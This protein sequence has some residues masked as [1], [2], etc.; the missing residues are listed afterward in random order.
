[1]TPAHPITASPGPVESYL[2]RLLDDISP[3]TD[4]AVADYI[5]ELASALPEDFAVTLA[6]VDGAIHSAG[7]DDRAFTIQS[8]SKPFMFAGAI[9]S[10]GID[11]V[12]RKVGVEPTGD[13]FNS[14]VLD[15]VNNRPYNPMVNAGAIAMCEMLSAPTAEAR[16][17]EQLDLF[18]RLAGRRLSVDERVYLS[19]KE[20]GHRNRAIAYMMLNSGMIDGPTEDLLDL[21][22]RQCAILTTTRD[23]A[24]MAATFAGHGRNPM[25]GESVLSPGTVRDV[26]SVMATCG[27]YDYAGQWMFDVGLPAKSGVSGGIIAVLPG[28]LGICV[29]S[30]RLDS[31]GNS[32]RG[33]EVCKRMSRDF[34]L[35]AYVDRSDMRNV[36][37]RSYRGDEVRS[38]RV[39]GHRDQELL[40]ELGHQIA[41]VETQGP[42]FFGSAERLIR[43]IADGSGGAKLV[44]VDLRRVAYAD[45][46]ARTLLRELVHDLARRGCRV[47]FTEA[48]TNPHLTGFQDA[49]TAE[50]EA[51]LCRFA[52]TLDHALE[53]AED[54]LLAQAG[55]ARPPERLALDELELFQGLDRA[56]LQALG[57][58]ISTYQ[59][60][61]GSQI[62]KT[63]DDARLIFIIARGSASIHVGGGPTRGRRVAAVGPGQAFGEMALLDGG[64][65]SA[66]VWAETRLLAYGIAVEEI[67]RLADSRPQILSTIYANIIRSISTRLRNANDQIRALQ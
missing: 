62:L 18:S 33:V 15:D 55:P 3:N 31:V 56:D 44:I 53:Q 42:L 49:F 52:G 8:V 19:E 60:D 1:M 64:T 61:A 22:F 35:H 2:R 11:A 26:L 38:D 43:K 54:A 57:P 5:P 23:L 28:Q 50:V 65:R 51:G 10:H 66:N 67:R 6:T 45:T 40:A 4:G 16:R 12:R 48:G 13:P 7:C 27:M 58:L 25:T 9:E 41:I 32:V 59:F 34:S 36:V 24:V 20:T 37:R 29:Y 21:Y 30:P 39:R 17:A 47:D 46:A 63:G 14:I